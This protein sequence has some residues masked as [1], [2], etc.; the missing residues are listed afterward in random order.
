MTR[1]VPYVLTLSYSGDGDISIALGKSA[2]CEER[3]RQVLAHPNARTYMYQDRV[4]LL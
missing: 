4:S 3:C 1:K 2:E